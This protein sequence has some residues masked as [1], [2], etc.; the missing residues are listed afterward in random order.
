MAKTIIHGN[1]WSFNSEILFPKT[2]VQIIYKNVYRGMIIFRW[3]YL[4]RKRLLSRALDRLQEE[5]DGLWTG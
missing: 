4:Q 2:D 1:Y 3:S 5:I